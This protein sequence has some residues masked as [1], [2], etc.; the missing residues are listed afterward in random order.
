[1]SQDIRKLKQSL[2]D[3]KSRNFGFSLVE[4]IIVL[5]IVSTG[6]LGILSLIIQ[7]IQS[8]DYNKNNLI[9]YQ[10]AQEG[11]ELV[12]KVRDSN[13]RDM[14]RKPFWWNLGPGQYYMDYLDTTPHNYNSNQPAYSLLKQDSQGFY[15]HNISSAATS[16]GFSRVI[17]INMNDA[18]SIQVNCR[19]TWSERNRLASYDLDTVLYDWR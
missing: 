5:F 4:T 9:A 10:L 13:W 14:P 15:F 1:M 2:T 16:S 8:Q 19:V 17:T 3:R 6:L 18:H 12:R 7:N 11:I